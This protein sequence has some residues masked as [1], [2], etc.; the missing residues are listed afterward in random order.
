[1]PHGS[2]YVDFLAG[3]RQT[4]EFTA[5]PVSDA[6]LQALLETMRWTGSSS[7]SQPWQFLVV[8][9][10]ATIAELSKATI[11]TGWIA[12]AP[13]VLIVLT[14]G[15]DRFAHAYDLGRVDERHPEVDASLQGADLARPIATAHAHLPGPLPQHR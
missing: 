7:N 2:E 3:Q 15:S 5:E 11:Y 12:K 14:T 13:L 10:P 1:M 6:D 8:R 9:D 4:R